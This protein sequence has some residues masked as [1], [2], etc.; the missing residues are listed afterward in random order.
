[1]TIETE[2]TE[3]PATDRREDPP[4]DELADIEERDE[5]PYGE[6]AA[7]D[8]IYA[9]LGVR[10]DASPLLAREMYWARIQPLLDPERRDDP[11]ARSTIEALNRALAIISDAEE[12][13]D[14]DSIVHPTAAPAMAA[15]S[16]VLRWLWRGTLLAGL[17]SA[18][19]IL[20]VQSSW[21]T[22]LAAGATCLAF[23]GIALV[24]MR[25]RA[26][27]STAHQR[28][29]VHEDATRRDLDIAY[30]TQAHQLL[31]R[32]GSDARVVEAL[33][34]LDRDYLT[35]MRALMAPEV[36]AAPRRNPLAPV[37]RAFLAGATLVRG[38]RITL[39]SGTSRPPTADRG[40]APSEATEE[41]FGALERFDAPVVDRESPAAT[42][43]RR[44]AARADA[45]ASPPVDQASPVAEPHPAPSSTPAPERGERRWGLGRKSEPAER[46]AIDLERR[47][48]ASF[49]ASAL[50]IASAPPSAPPEEAAAAPPT[51]AYLLL[52]ASVGV[53][54][55]PIAERPLRI[56]SS[57]DCDL[58][59]PGRQGVAPEHALVWR[60]GDA[61]VLHVTDPTGDCV[62][63]G[64]SSTWATLEHDDELRIGDVELRI[65]I[66]GSDD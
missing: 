4:A 47:L 41:P 15:S 56:G 46:P 13:A 25:P 22:A 49:K 17:A 39:P 59:L 40:R 31:V 57:P 37:G 36:V 60:R 5:A 42:P 24:V 28:L 32:L 43:A 9:L 33:N 34:Q 6:S 50:E 14:Y 63:N 64:R 7:R 55:V 66:D 35:A 1:M 18:V 26:P 30:Q 38:I 62:V 58:V 19:A 20:G 54:R 27:Q 53:R 45:S 10:E 12:R 65:A 23:L 11:D 52:F 61:V 51:P 29:G 2:R 44:P 16:P 8:D 3:A 48:A 21:T